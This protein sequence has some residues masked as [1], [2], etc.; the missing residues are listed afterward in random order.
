[1]PL[2]C[3]EP[4]PRASLEH[5]ACPLCARDND[6]EPVGRYSRGPWRIKTCRSCRF[7]YLENPPLSNDAEGLSWAEAYGQEKARRQAE[8]PWL[9]GVDKRWIHLRKKLFRRQKL[10]ALVARYVAPGKLC[11]VGCGRGKHLVAPDRRYMLYGIE[12]SASLAE[13]AS[14]AVQGSGGFVVNSDA[15]TA[16]KQWDAEEFTGVIMR[17]YLEHERQPAQVLALTCRVL[18]PNGRLIVK[19]PNFGSLNR[20]VRAQKWC[21]FRLPEHVNY[22]TPASLRVMLEESGLTVLRMDRPFFSDNIWAVATK[23]T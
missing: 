9:H 4:P 7:V 5:R 14:R 15:L 12:L 10:A 20:A 1:M 23:L 11:D 3:A 19:V 21:G 18:K 16:M 17:A 13:Q 2:D 22:F 6:H 8:E